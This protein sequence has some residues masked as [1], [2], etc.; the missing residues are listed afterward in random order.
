MSAALFR[1]AIYAVH[2]ERMKEADVVKATG[3]MSR[4]PAGVPPLFG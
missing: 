2:R 1:A 3:G 4:S